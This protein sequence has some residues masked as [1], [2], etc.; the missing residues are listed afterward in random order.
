[1]DLPGTSGEREGDPAVVMVMDN[2]DL[3]LHGGIDPGIEENYTLVESVEVKVPER[4]F[5][6][7]ENK[8]LSPSEDE[9]SSSATSL[10]YYSIGMFSPTFSL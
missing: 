9:E 7:L 3:Y 10:S 1:M 2:Y 4:D 6:E 5:S 8:F